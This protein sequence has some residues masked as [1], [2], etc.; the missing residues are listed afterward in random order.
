VP[1]LPKSTTFSH[2]FL[3]QASGNLNDRLTLAPRSLLAWLSRAGSLRS[4]AEGNLVNVGPVACPNRTP[5]SPD[6]GHASADPLSQANA[7]LFGDGGKDADNRPFENSGR[8]RGR[9]R[10]SYG[11][12]LRRTLADS[13]SVVFRGA[14]PAQSARRQEHDDIG[15]ALARGPP[16]PLGL[17]CGWFRPRFC[18]RCIRVSDPSLAA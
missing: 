2:T 9:A 11:S 8:N 4:V 3:T 5:F 13:D 12:R 10:Y 1:N 16:A 14:F 6:S 7:F 17:L 18:G 15:L